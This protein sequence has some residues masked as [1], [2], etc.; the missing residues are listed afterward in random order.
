MIMLPF[1]PSRA[2]VRETKT[3]RTMC[4]LVLLRHRKRL[5]GRKVFSLI[6]R[7]PAA[8]DTDAKKFLAAFKHGLNGLSKVCGVDDSEFELSIRKGRPIKNGAVVIAYE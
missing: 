8:S 2:G 6:F 3:Y 4:M 5:A 7:P 1:P